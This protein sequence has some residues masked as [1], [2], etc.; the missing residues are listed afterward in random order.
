MSENGMK[1]CQ[2]EET[3]LRYWEQLVKENP[4]AGDVVQ[5]DADSPFEELRLH[6]TILHLVILG[7]YSLANPTKV[8]SLLLDHGANPN[9]QNDKEEAK[10]H[11]TLLAK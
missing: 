11:C 9:S 2:P 7:F 10:R 4:H 8:V 1:Q 3:D 6:N 5:Y